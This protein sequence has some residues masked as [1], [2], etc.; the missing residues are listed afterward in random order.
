MKPPVKR[1]RAHPE[2]DFQREVVKFLHM[3][4][5][6]D[7]VVH[8]SPNE[9]RSAKQ[10]AINVGMGVFAGWA[11]ICI[12]AGKRMVLFVELKSKDGRQSEKQVKFQRRV[13]AM[14]WPYVL[15]RTLDDLL[16]ALRHHGI[17]TRIISGPDIPV[18]RIRLALPGKGTA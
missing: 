10:A 3:V 16:A 12:L 5:W 8:A 1:K 17:P 6:P 11:D 7:A 15:I 14:G 4:L 18:H 9:E 2:A 13:E